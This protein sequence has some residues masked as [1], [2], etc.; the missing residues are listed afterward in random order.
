M[1]PGVSPGEPNRR[2]GILPLV[3]FYSDQELLVEPSVPPG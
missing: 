3:P 2:R 1:E